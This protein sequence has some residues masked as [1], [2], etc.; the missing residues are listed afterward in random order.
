MPSGHEVDGLVATP[1]KRLW[2]CGHGGVKQLREFERCHDVTQPDRC[3]KFFYRWKVCCRATRNLTTPIPQKCIPNA[4]TWR[5]RR[6]ATVGVIA[7]CSSPSLARYLH[8]RACGGWGVLATFLTEGI[9][10]GRRRGNLGHERCEL[11][12]RAAHPANQASIRVPSLTSGEICDAAFVGTFFTSPVRQLCVVTRLVKPSTAL[13]SITAVISSCCRQQLADKLGRMARRESVILDVTVLAG[14][15]W[16][17]KEMR[18]TALEMGIEVQ[19]LG[20]NRGRSHGGCC[21]VTF[22]VVFSGCGPKNDDDLRGM[23]CLFGQFI[24]LGYLNAESASKGVHY[25]YLQSK[26]GLFLRFEENKCRA[27]SFV[28]R[29]TIVPYCDRLLE[30]PFIKES[31]SGDSQ[32]LRSIIDNEGRVYSSGRFVFV[33]VHTYPIQRI[34]HLD[35]SGIPSPSRVMTYGGRHGHAIF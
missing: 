27:A 31:W 2:R 22:A 34:W 15:L 24:A 28:A 33:Q 21:S 5:A 16:A 9:M 23:C 13:L 17:E 32:L 10:I 14:G 26:E 30:I 20:A 7:G 35:S 12:V 25:V 6:V 4:A 19:W 11:L 3:S 8:V 29:P 18:P 1:R